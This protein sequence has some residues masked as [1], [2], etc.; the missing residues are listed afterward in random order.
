MIEGFT[1]LAGEFPKHAHEPG[2]D[3][4]QSDSRA[5]EGESRAG[6]GEPCTAVK[7]GYE[8]IDSAPAAPDRNDDAG[9]RQREE[10]R[11]SRKDEGEQDCAAGNQQKDK[12]KQAAEGKFAFFGRGGS[13][14][15]VLRLRGVL[16]LC[17]VRW[18]CR[19]WLCA[20]LG[21]RCAVLLPL[22][23]SGGRR[24]AA[25]TF[26]A[27]GGCCGGA[28]VRILGMEGGHLREHLAR[29][30]LR[31]AEFGND[32]PFGHAGF[33]LVRVEFFV[34]VEDFSLFFLRH[35]L[36]EVPEPGEPFFFGHILSSLQ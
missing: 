3:A 23:V 26:G 33:P 19:V 7:R 28:V 2:A 8:G 35:T 16:C 21:L 29:N 17:A 36:N 25:V 31:I 5:D 24:F 22:A 9:D 20:V 27:A 34:I 12:Y 14:R 11:P 6:I 10:C 30:L 32:V 13:C 4:G 18:L 15:G 1:E